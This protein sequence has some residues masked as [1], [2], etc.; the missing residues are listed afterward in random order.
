MSWRQEFFY[1]HR[2]LVQDALGAGGMG[3]SHG[4]PRELPAEVKDQQT[5][6]LGSDGQE[7]TSKTNVTVPLPEHVP[8]NS[9]VTVW[10]GLPQERTARVLA[11][12]L[13]PNESPLDAFLL[14]S[15]E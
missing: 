12:S 13:N 9:L 5:L 2:V 11:S 1:P 10:P 14:L 4:P 7:H 8:L 15:L 3:A 6:V